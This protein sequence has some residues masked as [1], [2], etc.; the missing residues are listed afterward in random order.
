[1]RW[2]A[3]RLSGGMRAVSLSLRYQQGVLPSLK[4]QI[5]I[6]AAISLT[7][8]GELG[9]HAYLDNLAIAIRTAP[10]AAWCRTLVLGIHLVLQLEVH[11]V[12]FGPQNIHFHNALHVVEQLLLLIG[13]LL[14]YC[15]FE[16]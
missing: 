10:D 2:L 11:V 15:L 6:L 9:T 16:E 3:P 13:C 14:V 4:E 1:M 7:C 12:A 8:R 5:L